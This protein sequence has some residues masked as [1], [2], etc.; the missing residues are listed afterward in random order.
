MSPSGNYCVVSS[1]GGTVAYARDLAGSPRPLLPTSEHSDIA[2]DANGDDVY[3]S[4]DFPGNG[5]VF[6]INLRSGVR[7]ALVP[8]YLGGGSFTA[9]HVSG[10]GF[11]RPGWALVSTY[12]G[13]GPQRWYHHKV[14]AVQLKADPVVYTLAHHRAVVPEYFAEP[15]ASVNRDFTKVLFN[16]NWGSG[17][18]DVDAYLIDLP[19]DAVR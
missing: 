19:G 6:M 18:V 10:K 2:I 17:N 4:I 5:E 3:V 15:H 9:L 7:T 13:G 16:S 14:F 12:S 8:T 1:G 11:R